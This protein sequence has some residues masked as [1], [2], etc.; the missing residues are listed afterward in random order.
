MKKSS[1]NTKGF[2]LIG[3]LAVV[4]VLVIAGLTGWL[5]WNESHDSKKTTTTNNSTSSKNTDTKTVT[6]PYEGWKTAASTWAGF[7]VKYPA[8]WKYNVMVGR[9]NAEHIN[10]D[11]SHMRITI[12]SYKDVTD[13]T[14]LDCSQTLNTVNF[15][16][17]NLGS[18]DL[19]TVTYKLDNR[20]GNALVLE[21]PDST[22]YIPSKNPVGV[23]TA[24]RGISALDSLEAY[25][26]ETTGEFTSNPDFKTAQAILQSIAY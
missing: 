5:V 12:D 17:S 14:C 19:K 3:V 10:I 21:L 16:A 20:T 25:Q 13:R 22:Y 2:G 15:T 7:T 6:D 23:S 18:V 26:A 4:L 11:S 8:D 24:F 9:D 1:L